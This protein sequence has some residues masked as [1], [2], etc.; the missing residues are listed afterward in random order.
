[1]EWKDK[2]IEFLIQN[3]PTYLYKGFIAFLV[4]FA[5]Y[6][7]GRWVS[8]RVNRLLSGRGFEP[9][10]CMLATRLLFILM[11]VF[12]VVIA[13]DNLG[14][15][16]MPLLAGAGVLGVGVSLAAQGVL[17]NMV[18]GLTIIFTK[19]FRVGE[20]VDVI[21]EYGQVDKIELM[22]TTLAH[23]DRS[24]VIIPNRKIVGEVMHNYGT[25]R[26]LDLKVGVSYD[27]NLADVT[28][29]VREVLK[30][31]P[32]VLK[33]I[34]PGIG[35][36]SLEDSCISIAIKPWVGVADFGPAGTEIYQALIEKFRQRNIS[37][38]FPQREIRVLNG[39]AGQTL[40]A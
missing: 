16:I 4:L 1:M 19:P 18:A 22:S 32:R 23:G 34:T 29:T 2:A 33:E 11:L 38:P 12:A 35:I 7:A 36:A 17:G 8:K 31:N 21:G 28:A 25:I 40:P 37:M 13:A 30:D 5:G 10:V 26:Q 39:S 3:G 14:F 6:L 27:S 24:R 9:P 20:Y 15:E